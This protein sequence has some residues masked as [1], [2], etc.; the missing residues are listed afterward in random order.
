ME[1]KFLFASI[2]ITTIV[3]GFGG[4]GASPNEVNNFEAGKVSYAITHGKENA[5][6]TS[7]TFLTS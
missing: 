3:I 4:I 1:R 7:N 5:K 6:V 2:A